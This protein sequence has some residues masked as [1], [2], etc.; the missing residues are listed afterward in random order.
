MSNTQNSSCALQYTVYGHDGCEQSASVLRFSGQR[1]GPA[2]GHY[3][4]GN[5][6]RAL[7]PALMRFHSPDSL[8]PMGA[9]GLNCYAYCG[10]DPVNNIDPSGHAFRSLFRRRPPRVQLADPFTRTPSAKQLAVNKIM[11]SRMQEHRELVRS[12]R[13][14]DFERSGRFTA[15]G[16]GEEMERLHTTDNWSQQEYNMVEVYNL[17]MHRNHKLLDE[18]DMRVLRRTTDLLAKIST[19]LPA[20]AAKATKVHWKLGE[21][22]KHIRVSG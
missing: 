6:Y 22:G 9:G 1:K 18:N 16:M 4:L 5:G 14:K 2:T 7:N 3:L 15:G 17:N 12:Q 20:E 21:T 8:S 19:N 10:G 13:V 11:S